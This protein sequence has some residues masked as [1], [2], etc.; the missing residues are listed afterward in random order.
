MVRLLGRIT[1]RTV[2]LSSH[3]LEDVAQL[4]SR[5]VVLDEGRVTFDGPSPERV[6]AEWFLHH[7]TRSDS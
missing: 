7:T 4:A 2:L 3:I 1:D 6:D 5:I